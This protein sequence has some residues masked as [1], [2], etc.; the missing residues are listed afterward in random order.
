[1]WLTVALAFSLAFGVSLFLTPLLI[2]LAPRLGAVDLPGHRKIHQQAMPCIGGVAIYLAFTAGIL[3]SGPPWPQTGALL[4]GGLVILAVGLVD[5]LRDLSPY[6]KLAGQVAAALIVAA[7]GFRVDFITHPFDQGVISLGVLAIPVTVFWIVSVTN[8]VNLIDG[9]DGLAAGVSSL[10]AVVLGIVAWRE[11]QPLVGL[12]SFILAG[13]AAG[14][15]RYNF[16]PARIFMGDSG[17]MFLGYCL[18]VFALQGLT[19]STTAYSLIIP[20]VILGI[21]LLDTFFAVVRRLASGTPIFRA[22]R[23]HLH[24]RLLAIGLSHRQTVLVIYGIS[25]LYGASAIALTCLTTP[26]AFIILGLLTFATIAGAGGLG[27]FSLDQ[28]RSQAGRSQHL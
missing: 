1:M 10:A 4:L 20:F 13:S 3:A 24:H 7:C 15:L 12:W 18:A 21:P 25:A 8:A 23:D 6:L 19:K 11:G 28:T 27:I 2:K 26:Q 17:A 9:L 14:F 5:D 22:D 16:H